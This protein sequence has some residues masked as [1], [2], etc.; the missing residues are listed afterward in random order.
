LNLLKVGHLGTLDPNASGVLVLL[1]G[2][3]TKLNQQLS[4]D[5][6]TYQSLFKFGVET[7]TLDP[8]G[9]VIATSDIIPCMSSIENTLPIVGEIDLRVPHFSAVHINGERAYDLARRGIEFTPPTKTVTIHRFEHLGDFWFEIECSTG[10]YVRSLAKHLANKLG[11]VAIA[12]EIIRTAVGKFRIESAK[13]LEE[14][15]LT[16]LIAV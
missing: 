15:E 7:D 9:T 14:I 2:R 6:K 1:V 3:A 16:D 8:E 4:Q 11:T 12:Q 5:T 13:T 10:T